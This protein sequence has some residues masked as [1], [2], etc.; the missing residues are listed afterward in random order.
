MSQPFPTVRFAPSPTGH[1]HI[2]NLR[3]A[4]IASELA[5]FHKAKLHV[6]FEDIDRNRASNAFRTAQIS[7]LTSL[8]IDLSWTANQLDHLDTHKKW[9]ALARE[10][11]LIYPCTCSRSRV[12]LDLKHAL[13][14][15]PD[16]DFQSAPHRA[17]TG[18]IY[19][20]RC[21]LALDVQPTQD[22][23]VD[24]TQPEMVGWRWKRSTDPTGKSDPIIARSNRDGTR[25]EPGYH[26]ACAV[27][28]A[29]LG[30]I[31][32]VRAWDLDSAE[33]VQAEIRG[34]VNPTAKVQVVHTALVCDETGQRLEKRSK[35]V[36]LAE[37]I[38][39][40]YSI[41]Q[42]INEFQRSVDIATLAPPGE[43]NKKLLFSC[44]LGSFF[45]P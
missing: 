3:T 6:R 8:R 2:G 9:F 36:T 27:D 19:S 32:I 18:S 40:S 16:D 10:A 22:K 38:E 1:F 39:A 7:D 14:S 44:R 23:R 28:D 21:R 33:A 34:F 42:I 35:G 11:N 15:P 45:R 12:R 26:L 25:F 4:W 43:L 31:L 37:L 29:L 24:T 17:Q 41:D 5:K 13:S 30:D 20:G